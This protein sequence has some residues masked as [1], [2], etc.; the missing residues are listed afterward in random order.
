M[1]FKVEAQKRP[2]GWWTIAATC[3]KGHTSYKKQGDTKSEYKCPYC[4]SALH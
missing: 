4:G 2:S 1:F 3:A